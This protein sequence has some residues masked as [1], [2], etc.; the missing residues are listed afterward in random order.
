MTSEK[1]AEIIKNTE[2]AKMFLNR[3]INEQ[4]EHIKLKTPDLEADADEAQ[5]VA[6]KLIGGMELTEGVEIL[7][8]DLWVMLLR[9]IYKKGL[10][11]VEKAKAELETEVAMQ[12][13]NTKD[14]KQILAG[15]AMFNYIRY[16]GLEYDA[17]SAGKLLGVKED[18]LTL[19]DEYFFEDFG[20]TELFLADAWESL[21]EMAEAGTLP[22]TNFMILQQRGEEKM[23]LGVERD[24]MGVSSMGIQP[25]EA[26]CR[27]DCFDRLMQNARPVPNLKAAEE[28]RQIGEQVW[29]VT[30]DETFTD[31]PEAFSNPYAYPDELFLLR[32]GTSGFWGALDLKPTAI[33]EVFGNQE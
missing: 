27:R 10:P 33:S 12:T 8:D 32:A 30:T 24:E 6:S 19:L 28:K 2:E 29:L 1:N 25:L 17:A 20:M 16:G 5:E 22:K 7:G 23:V 31:Y 9:E 21:E 13:Q 3:A 4:T 18:D 14:I 15:A 11:L 26:P